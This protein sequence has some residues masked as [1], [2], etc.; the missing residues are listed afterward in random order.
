MPPR[1]SSTSTCVLPHLPHLCLRKPSNP[2]TP[3]PREASSFD[4]VGGRLLQDIV[5]EALTQGV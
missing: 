5:D 2:A 1:R 3:A 4:I